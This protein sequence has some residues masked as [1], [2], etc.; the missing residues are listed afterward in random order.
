[1]EFL[2]GILCGTILSIVLGFGPA[3][4]ALVQNSVHYGF[5]RTLAYVLGVLASDAV[6]VFLMLTV[7]RSVDMEALL[8]NVWIASICGLAMI[9]LGV[10][11]MRR[12]VNVSR[13][14]GQLRV[15]VPDGEGSLLRLF[16]H[17]MTLNALNPMV[18]LFWVGTITFISAEAELTASTR[19]VFFT[20]LLLGFAGCDVLKCRLASLLQHWITPRIML[21]FNRIIG[22]LF[23]AFGLYLIGSMVAYRTSPAMREREERGQKQSTRIIQNIH[24]HMGRDTARGH[25]VRQSDTTFQVPIDSTT[26]M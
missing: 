4:F 18:W 3:F 11:S 20:G 1:M 8:H 17:G 13:R 12:R 10:Q 5:R 26:T 22:T 23:V 7:L 6:I 2:T 21:I 9:V 15:S 16:S 24:D 19:Y 25:S 14:K